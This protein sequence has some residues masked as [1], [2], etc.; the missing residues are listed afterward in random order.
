M[1]ESMLNESRRT[2]LAAD[3]ILEEFNPLTPV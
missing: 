2:Y 1:V 3:G